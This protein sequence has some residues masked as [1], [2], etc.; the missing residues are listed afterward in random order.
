M[1]RESIV[2][3]EKTS[4]EFQL[5]LKLYSP[6]FMVGVMNCKRR[7]I[8]SKN[9]EKSNHKRG[10]KRNQPK[11]LLKLLEHGERAIICLGL[12]FEQHYAFPTSSL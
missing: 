2:P 1:S 12:K 5:I 10:I 9:E 7:N 3:K 6:I 4:L 8:A 11:S